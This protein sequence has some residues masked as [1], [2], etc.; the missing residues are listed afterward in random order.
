VSREP[1]LRHK[2]PKGRY[3]P[4]RPSSEVV[5]YIPLTCWA[6][7]AQRLLGRHGRIDKSV[8]L[9]VATHVNQPADVVERV[10]FHPSGRRRRSDMR[11]MPVEP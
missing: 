1:L 8:I 5:Q 6:V 4:R 11:Y 10:F 7:D 3:T 2:V 9:A